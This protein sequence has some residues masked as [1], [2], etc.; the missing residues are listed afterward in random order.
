LYF[1]DFTTLK[2]KISNIEILKIACVQELFNLPDCAA[3]LLIMFKKQ[4]SPIIDVD[5]CLN[6]LARDMN[7]YES[8]EEHMQ[9]FKTNTK[10]FYPTDILSRFINKITSKALYWTKNKLMQRTR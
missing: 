3:E 5:H 2:E 9:Q 8:Y 6:L 7:L 4:L 10:S 1:R